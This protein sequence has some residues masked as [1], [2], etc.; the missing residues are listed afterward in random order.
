MLVKSKIS[1]ERK[2]ET[3]I[4]SDNAGRKETTRTCLLNASEC[5]GISARLTHRL[6]PVFCTR[7]QNYHTSPPNKKQYSEVSQANQGKQTSCLRAVVGVLSS[8][9]LVLAH[10]SSPNFF[11]HQLESVYSGTT[12]TMLMTTKMLELVQPVECVRFYQVNVHTVQR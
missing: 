8:A 11:A 3:P 12:Q 2:L 5:L 1:H 4:Q 7:K 6:S 9:S 10:R